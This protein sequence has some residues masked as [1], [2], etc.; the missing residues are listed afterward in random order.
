MENTIY[1]IIFKHLKDKGFDIYTPSQKQGECIEP[2]L[3]LRSAGT[4]QVSNFSS[5]QNL[6]DILCYVPKN[7]FTL[8]E[9]FVDSVEDAMKELFPMIKSAHYRTES[10]YDD[11]V[12]GHMV[13]T[14]YINYRKFYNN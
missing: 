4:V 1:K 14:Q 13:S 9:S 5:T 6:Y 11:S 3:V 12:K 10:F 8:M 2:Y 7:R